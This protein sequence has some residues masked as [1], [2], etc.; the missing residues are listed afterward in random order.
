VSGFRISGRVFAAGTANP[1]PGVFVGINVAP[2]DPANCCEFVSGI[3]SA[4][5]G[6]FSLV[7]GAGTYVLAI[8]G[9]SYVFRWYDGG[10][11][12]RDVT[13]ATHLTPTTD[14]S[15]L[16]L[17]A[18]L[19]YH[20]GGHVSQPGGAA[21]PRVGVQAQNPDGSGGCPGGCGQTDDNGNFDFALE[22]GTWIIRFDPQQLNQ[23]IGTTYLAQY[24]SGAT[25]P[26]GATL[27]NA[28]AGGSQGGVD[29]T[30]VGGP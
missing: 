6:S 4:A 10:A 16:Q 14:I 9:P 22:T 1:I 26:A 23:L 8:S 19:G 18:I 29:A 21:A 2:S 25:T 30:L 12:T 24:W 11:G 15:G 28:S 13:L 27:V 7:A 5:D 20:I 3:Q 17:Q